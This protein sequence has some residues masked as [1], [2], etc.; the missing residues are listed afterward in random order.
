MQKNN[1]LEELRKTVEQLKKENQELQKEL[2]SVC[3]KYDYREVLRDDVREAL[4]EYRY[5]DFETLDDLREK[6]NDDLFVRD[7][8][9]GNASGSYFCNAWKAENCLL[10]NM[11]LL[12]EAAEEFGDDLGELVKR[13]SEV[14]DVTIRCYLLYDAIADVLTEI[15]QDFNAA[16]K[17]AEESENNK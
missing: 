15:E 13:G 14:C 10:H 17:K 6:L 1:E 11:D 2:C 3:E 16:H 7:S 9:T 5:T 12:E 4:A 8:V